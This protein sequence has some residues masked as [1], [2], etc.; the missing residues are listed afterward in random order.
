MKRLWEIDTTR[1]LAIVA[2][3][4]FH[5]FYILAEFQFIAVNLTNG[6]WWIFPRIIAGTFLLLVGI[7]LTL[8]HAKAGEKLHSGQVFRKF[9]LRSLKIFG[10]GLII[11]MAS[12][13]LF[14]DRAVYFG[15]LHLIGLAVLISYPLLK[16]RY[17]NLVCGVAVFIA[18]L[19]LGIPRFP[20]YWLL[21]LG[22]RPAN[23]YPV[24]Y[25]PLLPWYGF[26]LFG[27]FLG[28]SLYKKGIRQFMWFEPGN[29]LFLRPLTFLGRHSLIIYLLHLPVIY[30]IVQ[31]IRWLFP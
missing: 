11:T 16:Y 21:W 10:L 2:M 25:L 1:G 28:N 26:V 5:S 31:G 17:I 18:G 14:G 3:I 13:L 30:G 23:Y 7:S 15:I 20:F 6:F 8:S 24:D 4:I 19:I 22:L 9:L 12:L 27:M 29:R